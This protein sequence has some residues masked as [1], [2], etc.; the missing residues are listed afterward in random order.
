MVTGRQQDRVRALRRPPYWSPTSTA[1]A[2]PTASAPATTHRAMSRS[3]R[4]R[5]RPHQSANEDPTSRLLR[6]TSPARSLETRW[7]RAIAEPTCR[8]DPGPPRKGPSGR[9]A[10]RPAALSGLF[11]ELFVL[12]GLAAGARH[13]RRLQVVRDRLLRD[14]ALGDVR[15]RRELEHDVQQRVL[16]DRAQAARARLAL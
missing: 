16:D 14:R 11:G 15:A 9:R 12:V 7:P 8:S 13:K 3:A 5:S 10:P 4:R 2:G 6:R 1:A